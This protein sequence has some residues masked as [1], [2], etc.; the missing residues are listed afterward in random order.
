M[1]Q[2]LELRIAGEFLKRAP[3]LLAGFR[4]E[5]GAYGGQIHRSIVRLRIS[6]RIVVVVPTVDVFVLFVLAH[7]V[8]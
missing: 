1:Q 3:I 4:L 5:L 7:T 2:L 6:G 8:H